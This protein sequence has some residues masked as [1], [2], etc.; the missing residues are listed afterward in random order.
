MATTPP[1]APT[2]TPPPAP[3]ATGLATFGG[4]CFWCTEAVFLRLKGVVVGRSGY[5]GG[6]SPNPTYEQV[7]TGETGHAEV[8]QVTYDPADGALRRDCSRSS[9]RP[10]TPRRSTAR[11]PTSGT[12]YRSVDFHARRRQKQDGRGGQGGARR[13]EGVRPPDRDGDRA[14]S[15]P[16]TRPRTTTRTTTTPNP[17]QGYCRVVIAPKLEKLEKVFADRLKR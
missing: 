10:T 13:R 3:G 6:T 5:A 8:I 12:Q 15:R 4:G 9:A 7:C 17:R 2:P 14:A 1:P 16:S 11:A